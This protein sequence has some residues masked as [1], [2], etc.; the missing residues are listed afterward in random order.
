VKT[1]PRRVDKP[2]GYELIW[3]ETDQYAGKTL[4]IRP[5]EALSVQ[6][7]RSKDETLYLRSGTIRLLVGPDPESLVDVG[8]REG[9]AV[10]ISPGTV[11]RIEAITEAEV[12]EASTPQLEDVVRLSDRYG[13]VDEG[14]DEA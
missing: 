1:I 11:H 14:G 8:L 5:G 12:L 10:R 7:H 3:A 13:R 6:L 2:W 9:E 4:W